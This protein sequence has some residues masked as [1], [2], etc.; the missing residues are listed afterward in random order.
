MVP[1]L[2]E[3]IFTATPVTRISV[4]VPK[5]RGVDERL[6]LQRGEVQLKVRL[7]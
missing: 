6:D 7:P 3:M 2:S 4:R 1:N 5:P